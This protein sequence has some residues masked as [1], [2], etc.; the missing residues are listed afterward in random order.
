MYLSTFWGILASIGLHLT[1]IIW[2]HCCSE[3]KRDGF[4]KKYS[5]R[6]SKVSKSLDVRIAV[7]MTFL[8]TA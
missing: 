7:K 6:V 2:S 5:K 8:L 1:E 4:W 3:R